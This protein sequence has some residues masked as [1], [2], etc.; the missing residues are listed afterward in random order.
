MTCCGVPKT[1]SLTMKT[2]KQFTSPRKNKCLVTPCS[3]QPYEVYVGLEL[4]VCIHEK[5]EECQDHKRF[6]VEN[7]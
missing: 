4:A 3:F 7:G 5:P 1:V 2:H 6:R